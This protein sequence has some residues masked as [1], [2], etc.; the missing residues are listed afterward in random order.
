MAGKLIMHAVTPNSANT[1]IV[2]MSAGAARCLPFESAEELQLQVGVQA[3]CTPVWRQAQTE[4]P[5]K[6]WEAQ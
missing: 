5:E 4:T 1:E 6:R 2:Y 3:I